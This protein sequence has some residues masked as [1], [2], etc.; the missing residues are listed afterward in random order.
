M[1]ETAL[2]YFHAY[3]NYKYFDNKLEPCVIKAKL[4]EGMANAEEVVEAATFTE[5]IPFMI[6]FYNDVMNEDPVRL[7]EILLH[8][9]IHQYCREN[10]IYDCDRDGTHLPVFKEIA[11]K[12]GLQ[13]GYILTDEKKK[14]FEAAITGY[15]RMYSI[16]L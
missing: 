5:T 4:D 12:H 2:Q 1:N 11:E 9:M 15:K 7:L 6:R 8:E 14:E 3:F 16:D 10:E 13:M